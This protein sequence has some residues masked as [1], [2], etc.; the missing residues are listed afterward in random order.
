MKLRHILVSTFFLGVALLLNGCEHLVVLNPKGFI[1]TQ[2]KDLLFISV[3]LMLIVVIPVIVLTFVIAF[4]ARATNLKAKYTPDWGHSTMLE[5][6]CW[7]IPVVIITG[8]A[9]LTWF[10]THRL[11]PYRPLISHKEPVRIQVI[12]LNWRWLFIYPKEGIATINAIEFPVDTPVAFSITSNGPMGG[13]QIAQLGGQIYSMAGMTTKL[14]LISEHLGEYRGNSVNYSGDGFA[15][16]HFTAKVVSQAD[17]DA[18]VRKVK[19]SPLKLTH[20]VYYNQLLPN[21]E[22]AAVQYFG[23]VD[24]HLFEDILMKFMMPMDNEGHMIEAPAHAH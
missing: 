9:I 7:T 21:S 2:E 22:E 17:F 18:W 19:E 16:M 11:D 14:H 5:V 13:F 6:V 12:S 4:K 3:L 20:E 10:S 15:N 23:K 1:A 24:A 8:L